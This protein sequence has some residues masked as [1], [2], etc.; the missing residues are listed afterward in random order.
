MIKEGACWLEEEVKAAGWS[1][2]GYQDMQEVLEI[3]IFELCSSRY[4][5]VIL[6]KDGERI[7]S[8][9]MPCRVSIYKKSNGKTCI[10]CLNLL[11]LARPLGGLIHEVMQQAGS[12]TEEMIAR[13]L[14]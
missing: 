4:S 13:T 5:A 1:I 10:T 2:V 12:E 6:A 11:L 8:P 3:R 14:Q 7:G 9:L